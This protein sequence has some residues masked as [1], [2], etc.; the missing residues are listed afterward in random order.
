MGFKINT[1][2][3]VAENGLTKVGSNIQLGGSLIQATNI[4]FGANNFTETI[5]GAGGKKII[6]SGT[7]SG[8]A[9]T[10]GFLNF[11]QT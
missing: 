1:N 7:A 2:T 4:L 9:S 6:G 8:S 3:N 11:T 5:N 10:G